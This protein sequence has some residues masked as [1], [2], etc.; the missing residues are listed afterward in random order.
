MN[1][2]PESGSESGS[3]SDCGVQ[4][5]SPTSESTNERTDGLTDIRDASQSVSNGLVSRNDHK[6]EE[7]A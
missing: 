7:L 2:N 3:D 1:V 4:L 6:S 5:R